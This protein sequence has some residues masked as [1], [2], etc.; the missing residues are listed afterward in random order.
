ME[1]QREVLE[2]EMRVL[3]DRIN[4]SPSRGTKTD[5]GTSPL[6]RQSELNKSIHKL[7]HILASSETEDEDIVDQ[8]K[9]T[10]LKQ[11][12]PSRD[13]EK[14]VRAERNILLSPG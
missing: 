2:E 5:I 8:R 1:R 6:R 14:Q 11:G 4:Q 3:S 9:T 10:P 7:G 12:S 13:I